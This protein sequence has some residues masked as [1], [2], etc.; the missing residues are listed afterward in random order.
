MADQ[1]NEKLDMYKE[2]VNK[3][4]DRCHDKDSS[5]YEL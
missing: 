4:K 1:F 2:K 5:I 3:Y